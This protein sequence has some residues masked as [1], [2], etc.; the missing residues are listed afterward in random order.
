MYNKVII[1][2]CD[3]FL[4]LTT[5][6]KHLKLRFVSSKHNLADLLSKSFKLPKLILL[7]L[8]F[9]DFEVKD[10]DKIVPCNNEFSLSK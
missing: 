3:G 7:R 4:K 1:S 9:K 2:Q 5:D 10:I 6:L 8:V